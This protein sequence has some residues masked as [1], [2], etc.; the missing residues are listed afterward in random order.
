MYSQFLSNKINGY[1]TRNNF[2]R[3]MN[4]TYAQTFEQALENYNE[5]WFSSSRKEYLNEAFKQISKKS[6]FWPKRVLNDMLDE[7]WLS[8]SDCEDYDQKTLA[9]EIDML[10]AKITVWASNRKH[11]TIT[12]DVVSKAIRSFEKRYKYP[13]PDTFRNC[14]M[15]NG[16]YITLSYSIKYS[17]LTFPNKNQQES[18]DLL[19]KLALEVICDMDHTVDTRLFKLCHAIYIEKLNT[20]GF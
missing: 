10:K 15:N 13:C 18:L 2:I 12:D 6:I 3:S 11:Q 16:A 4:L 17:D 1:N 5:T 8:L 9:T 19:K 20:A 7:I 14:W